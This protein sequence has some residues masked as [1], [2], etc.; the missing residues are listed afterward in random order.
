MIFQYLFET[1]K[2]FSFVVFVCRFNLKIIFCIFFDFLIEKF[3]LGLENPDSKI[4]V[5]APETASYE[6]FAILFDP[7]IAEI[8]GPVKRQPPSDWGRT[9]LKYFEKNL[10][11]DR[12]Y[13]KK[14]KIECVR[15]IGVSANFLSYFHTMFYTIFA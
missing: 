10:D 2:R 5:Y 11:P 13:I 6:D 4:G 3:D 9:N 8:H 1:P 15:N 12:K 14:T 7:I